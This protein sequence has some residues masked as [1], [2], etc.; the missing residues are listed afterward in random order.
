MST[1]RARPLHRAVQRS[2]PLYTG[3]VSPS[4]R[5]LAYL[6]RY[7]LRY[8]AGIGCLILA[9]LFSLSIPWTVKSAVDT[10][11]R[12]GRQAA[13]G[14][15]LLTIL[16]L[17]V[18]HGLAR[19]G[20]RFAIIGAGQWIEHDIRA[21]LYAHLQTLPPLYYH[22]HRTGDLM[23]RASNDVSA[24]RSLAGFG[25]VALIG[26][27]FTFVGTIGAMWLIDPWLTLYAIVP[28][29]FLILIVRRF[30]NDVHMRST[31]V[32]EQL[33]TLSAKGQENL[34]GM[35]GVRRGPQGGR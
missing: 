16:L 17:A 31:A 23:S 9:A 13:L 6:Y 2:P 33:G 26:T 12:E 29:P 8:A 32:Q 28:F 5:L 4:R 21:D 19:L 22:R 10:L 25:G 15:Y 34:T 24:L 27:V 18:G 7:R 35:A 14:R 1:R 11:E 20:S 3:Q 30:N